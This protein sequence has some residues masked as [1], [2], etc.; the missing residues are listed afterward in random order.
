MVRRK[1]TTPNAEL[2]FL[3]LVQTEGIKPTTP[4]HAMK[5]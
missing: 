3:Q 2:H 5:V 4:L 1:C